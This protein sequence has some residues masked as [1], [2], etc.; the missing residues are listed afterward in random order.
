MTTA[1]STYRLAVAV[2]LG[3]A[4]FLA[5]GIGALGII[6]DGGRA[7]RMYLAVFAVLGVGA[8]AARLRPAGMAVALTATAIT[9][10]LV[11]VVA[12]VGGFPDA[13]NVS[14]LDVVALTVMYAGLFGLS[15]WLVRRAAAQ[16]AMTV[17]T[18]PSPAGAPRG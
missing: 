7:D 8:V 13:E 1:R 17:T 4:L 14:V 10:V 3:T 16:S 6:G 15:A 11:A 5:F 18:P 12:L 2:A 9:Q